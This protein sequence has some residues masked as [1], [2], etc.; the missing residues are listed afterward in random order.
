MFMWPQEVVVISYPECKIVVGTVDIVKAVGRVVRGF[1]GSAEMFDHLLVR[2]V[3]RGNLIIVGQPDHLCDAK[4]ELFTVLS[5]KLLCGERISTV[6]VCNEFEMFRKFFQISE[7]HAHCKDAGTYT[8]IVRELI[9]DNGSFGSI[10]DEPD[11]SF[12]PA[13]L[14][15]GFIGGKDIAGFVIEVINKGF[16]AQSCSFAVV[17]NT[18]MRY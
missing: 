12:D 14:Y 16:Y 1:I 3:F 6:S 17:S 15:V 13:D 11:V 5:E 7:C 9:S 2:T 18:L 10:H 8:A 4:L